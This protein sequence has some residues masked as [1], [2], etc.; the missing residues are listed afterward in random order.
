M[1]ASCDM[2]HRLEIRYQNERESKESFK[3][4]KAKKTKMRAGKKDGREARQARARPARAPRPGACGRTPFCHDGYGRAKHD[5]Y[6]L[7]V[8][9]LRQV[10]CAVLEL[11]P[12]SA[13]A[14]HLAASIVVVCKPIDK[15]LRMRADSLEMTVAMRRIA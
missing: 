7:D 1:E 12:E 9:A 6:V 3:A 13:A 10:R 2:Y 15:L 11:A 14:T 5:A 4:F 8:G